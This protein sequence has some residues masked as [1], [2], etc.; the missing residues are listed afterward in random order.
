[1]QKAITVSSFIRAAKRLTGN[2]TVRGAVQRQVDRITNAE[3]KTAAGAVIGTLAT[4]KAQ[5][6]ALNEFSRQLQSS[7]SWLDGIQQLAGHASPEQL[8]S[9]ANSAVSALPE[10]VRSDLVGRLANQASNLPTGAAGDLAGAISGFL[11]QGNGVQ[12][13]FG[14]LLAGKGNLPGGTALNLMSAMKDPSIRELSKSLITA[15]VKTKG[16]P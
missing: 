6:G 15:L 11:G 16:T 14:A 3:E 1:M 13:L 7:G 5:L 2:A 10:S 8:K 12:Q 4:G 9:V